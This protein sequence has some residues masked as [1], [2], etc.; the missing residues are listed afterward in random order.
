MNNEDSVLLHGL[1]II[2]AF[3]MGIVL[4]HLAAPFIMPTLACPS[5]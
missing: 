5:C 2:C 3:V 1:G 4:Y